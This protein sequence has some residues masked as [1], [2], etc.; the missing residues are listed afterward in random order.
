MIEL[1]RVSV[2][3]GSTEALRNVSLSVE[4]GEWLA[5][6]GPN[7]AGKTTALRALCGLV[8]CTGDVLVDGRDVRTLG[9][10]E[11]AR[12]A[13]FVPLLGLLR[14]ANT[15]VELDPFWDRV[16]RGEDVS[17]EIALTPRSRW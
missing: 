16:S 7:G 11:L 9:R 6:I 4:A 17:K 1:C 14:R 13:A 8:R 2:R 15:H 12:L 10:R 3:L 5:L